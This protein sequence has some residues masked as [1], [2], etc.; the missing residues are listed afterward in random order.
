[1][2]RINIPNDPE[3]REALFDKL[4]NPEALPLVGMIKELN[5]AGVPLIHIHEI[6]ATLFAHMITIFFAFSFLIKIPLSIN[7]FLQDHKSLLR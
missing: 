5:P 1:M 7:I 2:Y 3:E 6:Q 4:N